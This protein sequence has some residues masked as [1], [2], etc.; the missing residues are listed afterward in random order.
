MPPPQMMPRPGMIAPMMAGQA[1]QMQQMMP[2][3]QQQQQVPQQQQI[4]PGGPG[5]PNTNASLTAAALAAAPPAMRKQMLGEKLFPA[6][7]KYEPELAGKIT[8][9]LLEMD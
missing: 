2:P 8:G 4:A 5:T 7:S 9:M 3:Q 6:V 1:G